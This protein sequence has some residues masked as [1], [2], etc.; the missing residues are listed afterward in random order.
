M[1]FYLPAGALVDRWDRKRTMIVADVV[2][3]IA[4]ASLAVALA[5]HDFTF[6]Q[7]GRAHGPGGALF[8]S[9]PS[10]GTVSRRGRAA[11]TRHR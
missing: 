1:L 11:G 5:L 3:T 10:R 6:A 8:G 7:V 9:R 4:L 2:R